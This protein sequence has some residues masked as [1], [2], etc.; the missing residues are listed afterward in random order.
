ML[1]GDAYLPAF[2]YRRIC[3]IVLRWSLSANLT[4]QR[5]D[6]QLVGNENCQFY[7]GAFPTWLKSQNA[8]HLGSAASKARWAERKANLTG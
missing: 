4:E 7:Q 3:A 2:A 8:S 1:N 5:Q 6:R